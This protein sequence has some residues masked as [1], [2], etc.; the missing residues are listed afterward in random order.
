M[1]RYSY[2]FVL[3]FSGL[4]S[5]DKQPPKD[6]RITQEFI[7]GEINGVPFKSGIAVEMG[8]YVDPDWCDKNVAALM[9][10]KKNAEEEYQIILL[11]Y[12][13]TKPGNYVPT[14]S[15]MRHQRNS[16]CAWDSVNVS[17]YFKTYPRDDVT[18]DRYRLLEGPFNY[19][20]ILYY[21]PV[22][23]E[24]QGQF[25]AKFVRIN[26]RQ[27]AKEAVDTITYTNGKF[28]VANMFVREVFTEPR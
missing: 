11:N 12:F 24:M 21:D 13:H 16:M 20:K 10:V 26:K 27:R 22:K 1:K 4:V 8:G 2:M 17:L 3:L 23:N 18:M 7:T 6:P 15:S 25:A 19:F 14:D 9:L 5:C 28:I